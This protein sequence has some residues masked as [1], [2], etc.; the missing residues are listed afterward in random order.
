[1]DCESHRRLNY[2]G[3]GRKQGRK[4]LFSGIN[5]PTGVVIN[6]TEARSTVIENVSISIAFGTPE[7]GFIRTRK[8][9]IRS[10]SQSARPPWKDCLT[11]NFQ[12]ARRLPCAMVKTKSESGRLERERERER[13]RKD[14][15]S[16]RLKAFVLAV[17]RSTPKSSLRILRNGLKLI[18]TFPTMEGEKIGMNF[19]TCEPNSSLVYHYPI[20]P[21]IIRLRL[22]CLKEQKDN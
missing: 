12:V 15:V 10:R 6:F 2:F 16:S 17:D 11:Y 5:D 14:N 4:R 20:S 8:W 13:E 18:T 19:L 1:M 9:T 7:S 3:G 22:F 21:A